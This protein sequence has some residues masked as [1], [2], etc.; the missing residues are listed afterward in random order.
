MVPGPFLADSVNVSNYSVG[1][2]GTVQYVPNCDG[3][4]IPVQV[5][6]SGQ[7]DVVGGQFAAEGDSGSL[8][9]T[10]DTADPV[11]L[12]FSASDTSRL[13]NPVSEVL[14]FLADSNGN[15]LTF[16]GGAPHEVIGCTL[17]SSS[18]AAIF[19]GTSSAS[20]GASSSLYQAL[21]LPAASVRDVYASTLVTQSAVT[22]VGVGASFDNPAEPAVLLFV[23]PGQSLAN[24]PSQLDGVRTE[25]A[26][27]ARRNQ[28][29]HR[30]AKRF[31]F[32]LLVAT[33]CIISTTSGMWSGTRRPLVQIQSA[34]PFLSIT[35]T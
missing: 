29:R 10:Q 1:V 9:V 30:L 23:P 13:G 28:N 33:E 15:L 22:A 34:R 12:F 17:P 4:G 18:Q 2:T 20:S 14:N 19:A 21:S 27:T 3:T 35:S 6:F 25:P 8:I 26:E 31:I 32:N 16:V 24:L 11:A 5:Q 7:I